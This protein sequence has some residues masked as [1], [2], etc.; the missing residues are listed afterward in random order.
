MSGVARGQSFAEGWHGG[1]SLF[2]LGEPFHA[3]V[4]HRSV[5]A[6]ADKPALLITVEL[7]NEKETR[8]Q[9]DQPRFSNS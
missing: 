2:T 1:P 5:D 8:A 9:E 6:A 4:I 3:R 7:R